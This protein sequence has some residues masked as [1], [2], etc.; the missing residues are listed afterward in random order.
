MAL[1]AAMLVL[2]TLALATVIGAGAQSVPNFE[3]ATGLAAPPPDLCSAGQDVKCTGKALKTAALAADPAACC[4]LC[5]RTAGCTAVRAMHW[6]WAQWP[7]VVLGSC[8]CAPTEHA[9]PRVRVSAT[10][11]AVC[12]AQMELHLNLRVM[13]PV[14]A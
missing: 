1:P 7:S 3:A 11:S 4:A 13:P 12:L 14:R 6:P 5:R 2:A 8:A 9:H 10:V